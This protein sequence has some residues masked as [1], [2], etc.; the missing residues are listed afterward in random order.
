MTNLLFTELSLVIMVSAG[1]AWL[2]L[3]LRQP[4][5]LAYILAGV[6]LGPS[7]LKLITSIEFIDHVSDIGIT[8]LLFL[9]GLTLHPRE[10]IKLLGST[11]LLTIGTGAIITIVAT[12]AL[13]ASG[14]TPVEAAVA[15]AAM[16]FSSTIL[17]IKLMPTTTLHQ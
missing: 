1:L 2:A 10:L 9:A 3:Y 7:V 13:L 16:M 5:I 17:V 11:L 4:I 8:L 6:A 15:G 14:L 12:L